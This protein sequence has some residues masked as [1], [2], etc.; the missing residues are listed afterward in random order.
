MKTKRN[1][2]TLVNVT[3][4]IFAAFIGLHL[5]AVLLGHLGSRVKRI[6]SCRSNLKGVHTAIVMYEDEHGA[7]PLIRP[8]PMSNAG[9][10]ASPT[11]STHTD[12]PYDETGWDELGDQ[13]MQTV[14]LLVANKN[15]GER[16][17]VCP[18][19]D[20]TRRTSSSDYGW[21]DSHQYSYSIQWPYALDADGD[22][23][24][25]PFVAPMDPASII[26]ADRSPGGPVSEERR[27][28][29][30][31]PGTVLVR[32]I[33]STDVHRSR[34]DS[35]AGIDGDDIYTNADGVPGGMPVNEH[36]TSLSI[37]PREGE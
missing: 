16:G 14:W 29:N 6:G 27:P 2:G 10:N 26:M 11:A 21:T 13:A 18:G 12:R 7:L 3:A 30:H 19:D 8:Q 25:Q 23:N 31:R 37:S 5:A 34:D 24:P 9:V 15:L 22:A 17:F 20:W 28:T 33:G 35:F 36:D 32:M 1:G 4:I